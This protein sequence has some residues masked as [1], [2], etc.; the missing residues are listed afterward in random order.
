[1]SS[2]KGF[3]FFGFLHVLHSPK[4]L[5]PTKMICAYE[6][7]NTEFLINKLRM[8]V[9]TI[10]FKVIIDMFSLFKYFKIIYY[11]YNKKIFFNS[12]FKSKRANKY[13]RKSLME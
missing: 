2:F 11:T 7:L 1:M 4:L 13:L 5:L 9:K 10:L 6:Y 12:S 3:F 8:Y